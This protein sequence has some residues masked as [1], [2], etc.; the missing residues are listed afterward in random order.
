MP[1]FATLTPAQRSQ[2]CTALRPM[3]ARAG[4]A[5][6]RAGD[7]GDTFYVVEAGACS[8]VN[9]AHQARRPAPRRTPCH[10]WLLRGGPACPP[11]TRASGSWMRYG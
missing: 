7:V 6:V 3:H 9:D 10:L 1:L 2:L 11:Q 5:I 8:V 4:T